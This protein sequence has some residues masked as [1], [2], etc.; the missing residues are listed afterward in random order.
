[1]VAGSNPARRTAIRFSQFSKTFVHKKKGG[2]YKKNFEYGTI[3]LRYSNKKLLEILNINIPNQK[4]KV[5]S[6]DKCLEK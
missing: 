3:S 5:T 1:M 4:E 2:T 6:K